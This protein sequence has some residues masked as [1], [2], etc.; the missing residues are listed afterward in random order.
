MDSCQ[1]HAPGQ[2]HWF[3]AKTEAETLAGPKRAGRANAGIA[4]LGLSHET[5]IE[6]AKASSLL[7][8]D[9]I[10]L[11]QA[12]CCHLTHVVAG[13]K[14]PTVKDVKKRL[15]PF[16]NEFGRSERSEINVEDLPEWLLI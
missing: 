16:T 8:P 9:T 10:P 14:T 6:A 2:R 5:G 3:E 15:N 4:A 1:L 13:K 11:V 12:A 7:A